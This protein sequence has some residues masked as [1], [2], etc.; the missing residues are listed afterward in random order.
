MTTMDALARV[1]PKETLAT[2]PPYRVYNPI[3]AEH[4]YLRPTLR[5]NLL[6]TL[7]SNVRFEKGEIAIFETARTYER[8]DDGKAARE[9]ARFGEGVLPVEHEVVCAAITGR[10][11]DRWSRPGDA[12]VDFFDAKAYL[13]QL[14]REIGVDALYAPAV[15]YGFVPGRTAE[16]TPEGRRI[17]VIGQVHPDTARAFEVE[18]DVYLF[19]LSLDGVAD[20]A[21]RQRKLQGFSRFPAVEQDIALIVPRDVP[22][23]SLQATIEGTPLVRSASVFDVY[24]GEQLPPG[25]KS[26]AF[27]ITWQAGDRTLTDEDVAK[28]QRKL[29][30]R[31]RRE[32]DADLRGG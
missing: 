10:R 25:K 7:A 15:E 30:E 11:L 12:S 20:A 32:F 28:A 22:A 2:Y 14:L 3:S 23:G 24:T 6:M 27:A 19:E 26:V 18:Q 9:D 17:G 13:D 29:V 8:P 21:T 4:E 16:I 31:L 5:A 1:L